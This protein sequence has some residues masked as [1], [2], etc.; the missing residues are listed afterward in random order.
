MKLVETTRLLGE[1]LMISAIATLDALQ[2]VLSG[3]AI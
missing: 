1:C 2:A 3:L